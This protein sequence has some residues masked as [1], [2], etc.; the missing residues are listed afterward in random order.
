VFVDAADGTWVGWAGV[1]GVAF[2][3]H[4]T[5]RKRR[6]MHPMEILKSCLRIMSGSFTDT[7]YSF[8]I[9]GSCDEFGFRR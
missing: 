4:P 9:E 7:D 1:R 2:A 3:E 8:E 5:R 6:R